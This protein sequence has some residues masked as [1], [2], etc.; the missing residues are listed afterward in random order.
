MN[1]LTHLTKQE[2]NALIS[3]KSLFSR[4]YK[5][6]AAIIAPILILGTVYG[7][8]TDIISSVPV[9]TAF[10]GETQAFR[11]YVEDTTVNYPITKPPKLG[12]HPKHDWVLNPNVN[13]NALPKNGDPI[14]QKEYNTTVSKAT[15]IANWDGINTTTNPGDPAL[16][17]GP[18]HVVQMMN[19]SSGARV[20]IWDKTGTILL[21]NALF[22]TMVG[23]P[24][25]LGD[26]VVLYDERADRWILTEFCSGCNDMFIA[27]STTPDP[28]GTYFTYSVTAPGF[29][30]YPKYSI[31]DDS[32]VIT[33]NETSA[34]IYIMDRS[35][36]LAGT[37]T[38]VQRFTMTNFGTIGFQAATPVS[39]M[40]TTVAATPAMLLRMRD[41]A[42]AG[43][44]TDAI[45]IWELDINWATGGAGATLTQ[46]Q[47]LN[48][49]PHESELCGYTAFACIPQQGSGTTLDPLREILMNRSMYRNFGTHESMVCAHVTD[50]NGADL[51]G[52]RWYE[53]RRTGGGGSTWSIY[54]EGTYSPDGDHRWMPTIGLS[55]SGNIGLA[56]NVAS[57][58]V[59]PEIRYT[60]RK[61]CDPLGVMTEP[62]TTLIT[63]SSAN[64][65]NRWGDYNSMGVDPADGETFW[66]T[67]GYN[68]SA[69]A[70]TRVG[71]FRIDPCNP[72]VQFQ[73]STYTVNE[74]DANVA[75]GCLDYY[76]VNVPVQIGLDPSQ[77]A[78][79]TVN[80]FG[81][82]A[83]QGVDYDIFNTTFTLDGT[84][85][86][87]T[88]I[89][90]VYNDN[91]VEGAETIIL[92]YTLNAN[93]GDAVPGTL[94]Q[95]STITINDDDL[96]PAAMFN[97]VV[98]LNEDFEAGFGGFTT[99][100]NAGGGGNLPWQIGN[101][102]TAQSAAYNIP[103]TNTTQFAWLND[104]ACN[105]DQS[106]VDLNFPVLDLSTYTTASLS[107]D[108]YFE[109]NTWAS[110]TET[111][112]VE[113]S[114]GGPFTN[115]GSVIA[116]PIDVDWSNQIVDLSPYVGNAAVQIRIK[117]SDGNGWL[118]GCTVDNV[119]IT[120]TVPIGIQTIVN[121]GAGQTANL[122]PNQTV[123]FYDPATS[124]VMTT[125]TNTST[126]DYGCVTVEVDRDGSAPTATPFAS[127]A[128]PDYLH[129]KTYTVTPTNTNP[130][131]TYDVTLY[132]EEAEVAA[133]EAFTGNARANAEIIKVAGNNRI[134]DVNPGNYTT[135]TIDNIP[136]TLGAFNADVTF[137]ASFVNGFSGFGVG[138]YNVTTTTVTHTTV[139]TN[140]D[141]AGA[142]TGSIVITASGGTTPYQYSIDG[143]IT[144]QA[145]NTFSGLAAG[146]YNVIVEDAGAVQSTVSVEVLTDPPAL[147]Y[148][149]VSTNPSC[150]G[151]VDGTITLTGSGGTGAL[152]YSIDGGT[153]F[154]A[155]GSFTGL[156]AAMYN[157]AVEDANGCQATGTITLTDPVIVSYT[158]ANTNPTCNGNADA[159][160][161][162][163][164]AGGTGALQYSIDGGTTFQASGSF[165]GL[166]ASIYSIVVEDANGCQATGTITLTNPTVV[167]YTEIN[168]D[169]TCNGS[170]DGTITLIG[171]GGTGALQYSIDGGTI[172]QASG[173]FTGLSAATYSIV[174][175]DA[176]GCQATG[177]ITLA[178][179]TAITYAEVNVNPS[180]NAGTDGSITLTGSGGTG[181]LQYSIDGGTAFQASGS[182]TGLSA[183]TYNVVV[184]DASGCQ[185]TG[186]ITLT[187]PV[188]VSYTSTTTV[189]NCGQTDG[190]ISLTG[191]G[192]TGALQYS[193]DGG[194]TFQ[195]TGNFTGLTAGN[196]NV[197]VEDANGCQ[198]TGSV[199][200]GTNAGP[201]ISSVT[202]VD[203]LCNAGADGSISITV[204]GGTAPIQY[205]IDGG[206]TFQ[207]SN[208]FAGLASGTYNIVVEDASS[209]QDV[210]TTTLTDPVVWGFT[211]SVTDENCGSL[212]GSIALTPTGGTAAYQ[213]SI[214]GGV[215]FQASNTFTGLPAG[216]YNI[217]IQDALG[218]QATE[219]VTVNSIGGATITGVTVVDPTCNGDTDGSITITAS[220]GTPP[221]QYSIDGG[222][223]F[224]V[225]NS[226][227][228]L[229]AA[230][231]VIV[232]LDA[233]PCTAGSS[234][235]LTD[236]A[237]VTY[238][239]VNTDPL[240][241]GGADGSIVLTGSG[242]TGALQY[243][244]DGG[245]TFQ[246]SG[247]FTGLTA[248]TYNVVVE[249]A[250][251][252]QATGTEVLTDPVV[253]AYTATSTN[254]NCGSGD[255][256]LSLTGSG[257][258]G[259]LQYSIDGGT[260]FQASGNFTNLT[261]GTY[262]VVI[263][264]A[265][266]CQATGTE[267][268]GS[269][270]GASITGT[271]GSNPTCNGSSDGTITIT[272]T[273]GTPPIQYSIDGGTTFQ[274]SGSF[275]G[276]VAGIYSI[277]VQDASGCQATGNVTLTNP[278][279][280]SYTEVNTN[281]S[282]NGN[283]DGT[284]T[285]TGTGGTGIL[286]YSIDG[287]TTFQVSGSFTGLNATTYNVVVEDAN[288]CQA[289]GT[290]TL[291]DPTA[292]SYTEV[293]SSPTCN[294]GTGGSITLT[295]AGGT[296][297][298]QYSIDGGTTFQASASFTGLAAA[299]HSVVVEDA[300]GC[301]ATGTIT[302]TDPAIVN[303]TATST[304]ENCGSAN[305]TLSLTGA[306]GTGA[307]QYSIDG[308]TTFQSSG[309][310]I[311]LS[312]G[313]YNVIVEDANGCQATGTESVG[314]AGGASITGI[315]SADPTC[316]GDTDGT[317][318]ITASGGTA[319][320][321][322][323]NDGG[324]TFQASASFTGLAAATYNV[325]VEDA[326]GCQAT[327]NVTLIDPAIVSYTEVNT[328]PT[329]NGNTD[330]SITLVG[331]GG[332]GTLQYSID[333][334]TTFQTSG[335]FSG[336]SGVSFNV[337]VEDANGCQATGTV[338]LTDPPVMTYSAST[339]V[340]N[341]GLSDGSITLVGSGGIG[342]LQYSIDGGTT[343]QASGSFTGL[344]AGNYNVVVQDVN[345]CQITGT[346]TVSGG[347][348]G[349]SIT[350]I[351]VT[352]P[353]CNGGMG[354]ISIVA[355]GGTGALQYSIDAGA[356][357]GAG[358]TYTTGAGSYLIVVADASGCSTNGITNVTEPLIITYSATTTDE[359]CGAA[360]GTITL[361][362][363]GGTGSLQFSIDGGTTF[364]T[365][366]IFIGVTSGTYSIFVQDANGCQITGSE[367]VGGAGGA[368]ISSV[369]T[370][371][372]ACNGSSNGTITVT[373]TGGVGA[374]QFSIDGGTT[375]QAT[376]TFTGIVSGSYSVVVEDA[377]GCQTFGTATLTDPI[378][379]T[380]TS[381]VVDENCGGAD[382]T[383]NLTGVGGTGTLQYS[384]D[385]GTTLQSSGAFT[386]LA[387]GTYSVVV[388]DANGCQVSG[389]VTVGSIG[390]AIIS[391][392]SVTGPTC[393]GDSDG[394]ITI[395][396][397]GGAAP[398]QY[399]IDGGL[400]YQ[401]TSNFAGLVG[402][403]Y[404]VVVQDNN[405][406]LT[407]DTGVLTDPA[408][409]ITAISIVEATCGNADGSATVASTGGTGSLTYQ[410]DDLMSQTTATAS[411][412]GAGV[413]HV[414]VTDN[415]GCM[416]LDSAIV[417]NIGDP[418]LTISSTDVSCNGFTD[419]EAIVVAIGGI[420]PYTYLWSDP[421]AQSTDTASALT[422]GTYL[423]QITDNVGCI[424][425]ESVSIS[426]P[427]VLTNSMMVVN[428]SCAMDNGLAISNVS[429]GTNPYNY[430]WDDDNLQVSP[431][432]VN[433]SAGI[434]TILITD[435]NG[436]VLLDTATVM[437]SDSIV[438]T[439]DVIHETCI[440]KN[441]GSI[442]TVVTG[443][444]APY[445]YSWSTGDTSS[446]IVNLTAGDYAVMVT[447]SAGC[448]T[449]LL[450]PI[451]TEGESCIRIPTAISPNGDGSNDVW[452]IE[453]LEPYPD[454][455]VEVYN[456]WGGL[457]FNTNSYQNDWD[458][459]FNSKEV[460][461]G[462]YY[463][464][465][466]ISD[467]ETYTGSLTVLR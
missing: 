123:H 80:I 351:N 149:E 279:A 52:I 463:F 421:L 256:T 84:V 191:A 400:T 26:P 436:C 254:E 252:C 332:T 126:W 380:Y 181:A 291:T 216:L 157:V 437:D 405:G 287:G 327:G 171:S 135:F 142:S 458:G 153:T 56:Y 398:L 214:T 274:A 397:T 51:A 21:N 454:A 159:T 465:V 354:T 167:S 141:C 411:N 284:I 374:L 367:I 350:S 359:N 338:V 111:A 452:A 24:A 466:K 253:V 439:V 205:S 382:G 192:G 212:N 393:F 369:I 45:E 444:F 424:A 276:L 239:S 197:V 146:S 379:I 13:P 403:T 349:P 32:Y 251:G 131:G 156:N 107:F 36:M 220:G 419:G 322:Y 257:G 194:A 384:V 2:L 129:S 259:S 12:Y 447:D 5:S 270:G 158:E 125:L 362:G 435:N 93:G 269:T 104:D 176:N 200:V 114:T 210:T 290:I 103:A 267:T 27:V 88:V 190:T 298:L 76:V 221:L 277:V 196:Y 390:G 335:S 138:I 160:I 173:S 339:T 361:T 438:I 423:V 402:G 299:T 353:L 325:V 293:N 286:Q 41:D 237:I 464:I 446:A 180:C 407:F 33:T 102:A 29:P 152:Q 50:V 73:S 106:D 79:I 264:D 288:G 300:N 74:P 386:G 82:T 428:T 11:D 360:D 64:N 4:N 413:Y 248:A 333:G 236:P 61:E 395:V 231:Y 278:S 67:A 343:F 461:A 55:A 431:T 109:A 422:A 250:N 371:D 426:E 328:N 268:V 162:L 372:P 20:Q 87:D 186:T 219:T 183:A 137:T 226:F 409:I 70:D 207:S 40:G 345:G 445:T 392:V 311:N 184:E 179:P 312:A 7:Q 86:I 266:G 275:T 177:T 89:I 238:T 208:S 66:F 31:W 272:A 72:T 370:T 144:F 432:A 366:G 118:Y 218:C 223:T 303:Y 334:G 227:T 404:S 263:E 128:I 189:E 355:S 116:S 222:T 308:G 273:G 314:S 18:N 358:S 151:G 381:V 340:E 92:D 462:I 373:A 199:T 295:G 108:S 62:E 391:S 377:N 326:S 65:S 315:T 110:N 35:S 260:S 412:I 292:V 301:Q 247:S 453:G 23:T 429:G 25:G 224:Q 44:A 83:T 433:L 16:D 352:D 54:Q 145:S 174:V 98:I 48:T 91:L 117:Y 94:N 317:I 457:V 39:L 30:D 388:Q 19:G 1:R 17:V 448:I 68:P 140:P 427:A 105:C 150:P 285:L 346:E 441:D 115:L 330:G 376:G 163:T 38:N 347:G 240:C 321:Q 323:S 85:L 132:Y 296:G 320:I 261:A 234:A 172:F 258:T 460:P 235:T 375:F 316:N 46:T 459:T 130:T 262:N 455:L 161:T 170:T 306:G 282:C 305:G 143:G 246:A 202:P 121:V 425:F 14:T 442:T 307:L 112:V 58:S 139:N 331:S 22:S 383:I 336:L 389:S 124:D 209:C 302:L 364:Q 245:V 6:I 43:A 243:S 178:D 310:F 96:A 148:T 233:G 450:V 341:C 175:E 195:V 443:G 230:T 59:F 241:N 385:G 101:E 414:T 9:P 69:Q 71:A 164:G 90:W 232:V 228:G 420:S 97:T 394:A 329:C 187:D 440:D 357:F 434:Y 255:G 249:D 217:V 8:K 81:G 10:L 225:S 313:T 430:Q 99:V 418:S 289:T 399:S 182:F 136:A 280:V 283:A 304:N 134:N 147:S 165:T 396:A 203:P 456:R 337:V 3:F 34:A 344:A 155:S 229:G 28:L 408:Q 49:S 57:S 415:N 211:S 416:V 120:G 271:M 77:P 368:T 417:G 387:T 119:N 297:V 363:S 47:V 365:S 213:Y 324:T 265:N 449:N 154:Q 242:G 401:S 133:W 53:L 127:A 204:S 281:P 100:N 294:G 168:V 206:T 244:I 319:P 15:Q 63:G 78:D 410:W 113:I 185:A 378:A 169:P 122:G 356:T 348:T 318:T 309:N 198:A 75:N 201:T 215:T 193:N 166:G 188:V 451:E 406:C 37:G 95:T 60:G 42:W 342:F 467:T